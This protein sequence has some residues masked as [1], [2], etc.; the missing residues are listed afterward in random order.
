MF[1]V[2][3]WLVLDFFF[4]NSPFWWFFFGGGGA[5]FCFCFLLGWEEVCRSLLSLRC[6]GLEQVILIT[7]FLQNYS[8]SK[9]NVNPMG[10]KKAKQY[11]VLWLLHYCVFYNLQGTLLS[12]NLWM[13][14]QYFP[15]FLLIPPPQKSIFSSS[16][17]F[18]VWLFPPSFAEKGGLLYHTFPRCLGWSFWMLF[19]NTPHPSWCYTS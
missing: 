19:L 15:L 13:L 16:Q 4:L 11:L 12:P 1:G 8:F 18:W 2:G 17:Y 5:V 14:L 7:S 9:Q 6:G 10:G 3:F